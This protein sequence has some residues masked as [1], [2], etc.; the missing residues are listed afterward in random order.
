MNYDII[1]KL[2]GRLYFTIEDFAGV[3][4]I[5][6]ASARV[7]CSRYVKNGTFIRIRNDFYVLETSWNAYKSGE[8]MRLANYLQVPSYVSLGT[9]LAF[10]GLT[11]QVQ[12]NYYESVSL[13]RSMEY[14]V[15][16]IF[17][18]FYKLDRKY[19]FGFVKNEN[20]FIATREKA[21][22]DS[23]YLVSFGKYSMDFSAVDT[24]KLDKKTLRK[25]SAAYPVKVKE[26]A[27]KLCRI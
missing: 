3:A 22:L 1:K 23:V 11:T 27:F 20:I 21:F 19:Y 18:K 8:F 10:Y 15:S 16:G 17:Y 4:G 24:G 12:R 6:S 9:A 26:E 5:T 25:M 7:M 2:G 13:K 14:D